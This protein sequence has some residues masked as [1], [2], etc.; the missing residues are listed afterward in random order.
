MGLQ[1]GAEFVQSLYLAYLGRAA[2]PDGLAYWQGQL[3]PGRASANSVKQEIIN[4]NEAT[5][6]LAALNNDDYVISLYHHYFEREPDDEEVAY[7]TGRLESG[8][9]VWSELADRMID[10]AGV[11]DQEALR[12]KLSVANYYSQHVTPD[13]YDAQQALAL[14][15][16]HSNERLYA[17]LL[18]L[19]AEYEGMTLEQVGESVEGRPLYS[20][21]L[22]AGPRTLMIVT[23]QHGDEPLGTEAALW[24]I[25]YLAG[26]SSEAQSLRE[27]VTVVVMPRVNPDGFARWQ[28]QVAG[29]EDVLDPRYNANGVELNGTYD[30]SLPQDFDLA[31][32]SAA[33][34][35]VVAQYRPDLFLD[36]HNQNTYRSADG[37]LATLSLM[38]PTNEDIDT[39]L[40]ESGQRAAVAIAQALEEYDHDHL[41]L[42]PGNDALGISRNGLGLDGTATLLLEQRGLQEMD[43][44]AQG[45][46]LDISALAGALTLELWISMMGVAESMASGSLDLLDPLLAL[47]IPKRAEAVN[48]EALYDSDQPF[49]LGE[50]AITTLEDTQLLGVQHDDA[51]LV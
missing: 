3:E 48:F 34:H 22:G 43:Q 9:F 41:T 24:L 17:A 44:L 37:S 35:Q 2:D 12:A 21:V 47:Q 5:A 13:D 20:A 26:N 50:E 40:V 19:D 28:E 49:I 8:D 18:K 1:S 16:L 33:V 4:S 38:W 6:Y 11:H 29:V 30:S 51:W 7:W 45:V 23:Q 32:E 10:A 15:D 42:Y 36:I 27:A 25:E 31:P 46:E 14:D 39:A